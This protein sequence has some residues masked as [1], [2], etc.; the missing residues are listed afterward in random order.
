M[1]EYPQYNIHDVHD[2]IQNYLIHKENKDNVTC[3]QY[4][5]VQ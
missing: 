3:F 4:T 5:G 2:P 1:L